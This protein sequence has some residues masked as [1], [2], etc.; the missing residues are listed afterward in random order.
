MDVTALPDAAALGRA[1]AQFAARRLRA[2]AAAGGPFAVAFATGASQL[3]TLRALIAI[4]DLPWDQVIGLHLD[5]YAGLA[6]DHPAAFRAYLRRELASRVPFRAFHFLP[7]PG[8]A[9]LSATADPAAA[10]RAAQAYAAVWRAH[11]PRLGL[12]GIGENGHLAF[13]DPGADLADPLT[14]RLV[15]LDGAC[16]RQQVAEGWFGS[17]A[18]VPRQALTVTLP[19][20]MAIPEL[21]LS[22]PGPRKREAVHRTLHAPISP[23]CPATLLRRHPRA[24]LF[25]DA[26][27]AGEEVKAG[28]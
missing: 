20:L 10:E 5:E 3:A 27:S 7:A 21:I 9:Q 8:P 1:A 17:L 11:P 19:A 13:N 28:A 15:T 26:A 25:L 4:R 2:L 16:R 18:E 22:V 14:V 6:E 24:H 12:I 23:A